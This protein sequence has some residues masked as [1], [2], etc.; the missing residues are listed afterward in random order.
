MGEGESSTE[1][2]FNLSDEVR[3]EMER[4]LSENKQLQSVSVEMHQKHH[5]VAIK[6]SEL[7]DRMSAAET[8]VAELKNQ[9]EEIQYELESSNHR[10]YKLDK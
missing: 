6:N 4:L 1:P 10:V 2:S 7:H 3:R 5:Q 9:M 8:Q